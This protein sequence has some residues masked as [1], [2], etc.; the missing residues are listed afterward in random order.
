MR[1]V[2]LFFGGL[3]GLIALLALVGSGLYLSDPWLWKR[4]ATSLQGLD[5]TNVGWRSP[6][7]SV[8]GG[9]RRL[10]EDVVNGIS[11]DALREAMA[12]A[13]QT[14]SYA[15]LIH[16]RGALVVERYW[17]GHGPDSRFDTASMHK[18][19]MA[20][21][22]G[23][24]IDEGHIGSIDD[25][26]GR[27]IEE[28]ANDPRGEITLRQLATM[29]SGLLVEAFRPSPFSKGMQLVIGSNIDEL[30]LSLPLDET[31]GT[32]FEYLNFSS[33]VLGIALTRAVGMRYAQYLSERLWQPLGAPDTAVWLDREDGSPR[34]FC[35]LL[36]SAPAW[37]HV[38]VL[39]LN[40]GRVDG[41]Q[42]VPAQWLAQMTTPSAVNPNY[43]LQVWLDSPA[44][45]V[46]TYNRQSTLEVPHSEPYLADDVVFLDGAG[47]QRVYVI[48][49]AELV[50][51]RIGK[52]RMDWD[53]AVLPNALLRGR[54]TDATSPTGP[55]TPATPVPA[56][57]VAP[58]PDD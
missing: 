48:P 21:L 32:R 7:E 9:D 40:E 11:A 22:L 18:S 14:E 19:V 49:S 51:V 4:Y 58:S 30:A 55:L 26:V 10:R 41:Q 42:I 28:W 43:G 20:L 33:Q 17:G 31:P 13:E 16:H 38:G 45:G 39:M 56:A 57:M 29:S 46:R 8:P 6:A 24:A 3:A 50:I 52:S 35:C 5:V 2:K 36:A 37:M 15:L 34:T 23:I 12:Y 53:D 54:V 1:I 25:P 27:Y 47:G 44:S